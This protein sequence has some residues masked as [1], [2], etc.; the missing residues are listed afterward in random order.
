MFELRDI[1]PASIIAVGAMKDSF[2]IRMLEKV[3]LFCI[4]EQIRLSQ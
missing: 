3:E 1:W 2:S 4:E